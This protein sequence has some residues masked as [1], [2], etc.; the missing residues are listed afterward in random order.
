MYLRIRN[1]VDRLASG[2]TDRVATLTNAIHAVLPRSWSRTRLIAIGAGVGLLLTLTVV[3]VLATANTGKR[4]AAPPDAWQY[5]VVCDKCGQRERV[6]QRPDERRPA[7][8]KACSQGRLTSYRR[9]SQSLIP[10][11]WAASQPSPATR[12]AKEAP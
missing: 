8:C 4:P 9:G 11:G 7:T 2:F 5:L 1:A 10:G 6:E 3:T 12:D